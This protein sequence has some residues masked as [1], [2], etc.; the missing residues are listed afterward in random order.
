MNNVLRETA[1]N[2]KAERL[3]LQVKIKE[4]KAAEDAIRKLLGE[5]KPSQDKKD[6]ASRTTVADKI[7][8]CLHSFPNGLDI[9]TLTN[10]VNLRYDDDTPK[11]TIQSQ[12]S[13]L[14]GSLVE[15]IDGKWRL[16][17]ANR[18]SELSRVGS[19]AR[20]RLAQQESG[21]R[22]LGA[23]QNFDIDDEIPF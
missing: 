15:N 12:L 20:Q 14:S 22:Q 6:N 11:S 10:A 1:D 5:D 9:N 7:K 2:L 8:A 18:T 19:N 3:E 13:R 17:F 23:P 4:M 16:T 21:R